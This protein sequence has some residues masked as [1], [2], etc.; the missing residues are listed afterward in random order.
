M[1]KFKTFKRAFGKI[2]SATVQK[3]S[4][5]KVSTAKSVSFDKKTKQFGFFDGKGNVILKFYQY[6]LKRISRLLSEDNR[7]VFRVVLKDDSEYR[8]EF[9]MK[10]GYSFFNA[11]KNSKENI[12]AVIKSIPAYLCNFKGKHTLIKKTL[13]NEAF[14]V[15]NADCDSEDS[16][17]SESFVINDFDYEV[18]TLSGLAVISFIDRANGNTYAK[19]LDT[20]YIAGDITDGVI[21]GC[22]NG[23][24]ILNAAE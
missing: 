20:V 5:D 21:V 9:F 24:F 22:R 8:M 19:A 23:E 1:V 10:D 4:E 15:W 18:Q 14:S 2:E 13:Y 3:V 17:I 6:D 16:V 12:E 11:D 7:F